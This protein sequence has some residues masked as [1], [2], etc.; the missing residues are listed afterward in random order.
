LS[1]KYTHKIC[2][3]NIWDSFVKHKRE[4]ARQLNKGLDMDYL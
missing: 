4:Q 3:H 1:E 2:S